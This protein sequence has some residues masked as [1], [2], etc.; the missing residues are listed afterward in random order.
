MSLFNLFFSEDETNTQ[1]VAE[2]S[3]TFGLGL[4]MVTISIDN[5]RKI[6]FH[7]NHGHTGVSAETDFRKNLLSENYDDIFS[8]ITKMLE[9]CESFC[10]LPYVET[11]WIGN[12][13]VLITK[14]KTVNLN[15][16]DMETLAYLERNV[17]L[18]ITK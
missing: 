17:L 6:V 13:N 1:K 15:E 9:N 12:N 11:G 4:R 5:K 7:D 10:I 18:K 8:F 14:T 3:A 2:V 16:L